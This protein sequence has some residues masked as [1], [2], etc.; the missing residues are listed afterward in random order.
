MDANT[1]TNDFTNNVTSSVADQLMGWLIVPSIVIT[2]VFAI[3]YIAH[4]IHRRRVDK[5]V[6]E[7]RDILR[8][9]QTRQDDGNGLL[10]SGESDGDRA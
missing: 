5:A 8:Q 7:I 3:L 9:V 4:L 1:L 10:S 6:F 2:L